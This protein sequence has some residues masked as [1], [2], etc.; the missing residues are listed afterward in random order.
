[1]RH[2]QVSASAELSADR[3]L[4]LFSAAFVLPDAFDVLTV[5]GPQVSDWYV[6][7]AAAGGLRTLHVTLSGTTGDA[8]LAIVCSKLTSERAAFGEQQS[9][10]GVAVPMLVAVD[11][12]GKPIPAPAGKPSRLAVQ[13]APA[14]QAQTIAADGLRGIDPSGLSGWLAAVVGGRGRRAGPPRRGLARQ[15]GPHPPA[16]DQRRGAAVHD[17]AVHGRAGDRPAGAVVDPT[18]TAGGACRRR[19]RGPPNDLVGPAAR[20]IPNREKAIAQVLQ[21]SEEAN[22]RY[23][24]QQ[25]EK[26]LALLG[27]N[28]YERFNTKMGNG[29]MNFGANNTFTGGN[30]AL[31]NESLLTN[32][33]ITG[34]GNR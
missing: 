15:R 31:G 6:Q 21:S 14:L 16:A 27:D 10:K 28:R 7:P 1:M 24:E 34:T 26:Q 20:G 22:M 11:D 25:K 32:G 5:A 4:R 12:G 2:M 17:P 9:G 30:N 23:Y 8:S 33:N 29:S 18:E 3:G 13:V 19:R